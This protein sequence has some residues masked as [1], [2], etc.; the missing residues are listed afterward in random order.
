[1][2]YSVGGSEWAQVMGLFS[3]WASA[4]TRRREVGCWWEKRALGVSK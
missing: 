1:M 4:T 3:L 2:M